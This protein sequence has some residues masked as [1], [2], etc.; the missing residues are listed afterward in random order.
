MGR[1]L[2]KNAKIV[3][4]NKIFPADILLEDDMI[5]KIETVI[6]SDSA[7]KVMDLEGRYVIPGAIDDQGHFRE[8]GLTHKGTIATE[9]RA[10]VVGRITSFME[11]PNS[12]PQTTTI[13]ALKQ[14]FEMT[15]NT[16]FANYSFLFGGTN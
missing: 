14:K 11:Q 4:D 1:L 7:T 10:A 8:P 16:A 12:N 3:N 6:S 9:S 15:K 2:L 13:E 5:L